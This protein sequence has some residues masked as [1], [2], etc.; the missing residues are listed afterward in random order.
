M[1]LAREYSS[2]FKYPCITLE[3]DEVLQEAGIACGSRLDTQRLT[4][5]IPT[6]LVI[7]SCDERSRVNFPQDLR[8]RSEDHLLQNNDKDIGDDKDKRR[9]FA[10]W[11]FGQVV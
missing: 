6:E 7:K 9:N 8:S 10:H 3:G 11:V 5:M 2:N 4:G 1:V